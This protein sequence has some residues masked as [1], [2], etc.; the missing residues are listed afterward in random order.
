VR[1]IAVAESPVSPSLTLMHHAVA[2]ASNHSFSLSWAFSLL[3][4]FILLASDL[5]PDNAKV[6]RCA[7]SAFLMATLW[8]LTPI[9]ISAT[10]LLPL[11]LFPLLGVLDGRTVSSKYLNDTQFTFIGSFLVAAAIEEAQ[12]HRRAALSMLRV[13]GVQPKWL[14]IGFCLVT[15]GISMCLSN[16]A[17]AIMLTPLAQAVANKVTGQNAMLEQ[18]GEP[19]TPRPQP[20]DGDAADVSAV[21]RTSSSSRSF[22]RCESLG[23]GGG[24]GGEG[25]SILRPTPILKP[26]EVSSGEAGPSHIS[27]DALPPPGEIVIEEEEGPSEGGQE[28]DCN[29]SGQKEGGEGNR[30]RAEERGEARLIEGDA[31]AGGGEVKRVGWK[32]SGWDKGSCDDPDEAGTMLKKGLA[33]AVAYSANIGGIA[34]LTGTMPNLVYAGQLP[35]L[36]PSA[37]PTSFSLWFSYCFPISSLMLAAN[38]ALLFYMYCPPPA[39]GSKG[40]HSGKLMVG[41]L[42]LGGDLGPGGG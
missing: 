17:T 28:G 29:A 24:E 36:F 39:R 7:A 30:R 4:F 37:E 42:G 11:V 15:F 20:A 16:T 10:A 6:S 13:L 2:W 31:S 3:G 32:W 35:T 5:D 33:L 1:P 23:E 25:G 34:T 27:L 14:L 21:G 26:I 18:T 38:V 19:D 9:P 41:S 12:L 22:S 40:F 8:M